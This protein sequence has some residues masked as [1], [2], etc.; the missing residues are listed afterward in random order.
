M[1]YRYDYNSNE[2]EL[3]SNMKYEK[4][5]PSNDGYIHLVDPV[6]QVNTFTIGVEQITID[7]VISYDEV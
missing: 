6:I 3:I 5:D 4:Q 7:E 1:V 2:L